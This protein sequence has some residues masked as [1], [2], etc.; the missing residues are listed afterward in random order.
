MLQHIAF[1]CCFSSLI[2]SS[3]AHHQIANPFSFE[4]DQCKDICSDSFFLLPLSKDSQTIC[5]RGCRFFNI[6]D[7][8]EERS[9][10]ETKKECHISCAESYTSTK[11]KGSCTIGCDTMSKK[12][13]SDLHKF[14]PYFEQYSA[15]EQEFDSLEADILLDPLIRKQIQMRYD[16]QYKIPEAYIRTM[17]IDDSGFSVIEADDVA[18]RYKNKLLCSS[19]IPLTIFVIILF[20]LIMC[21][22]K[23][24]QLVQAIKNHK[25]A[26]ARSE[27]A[28]KYA[29]EGAPFVGNHRC[30][31]MC[32]G[33]PSVDKFFDKNKAADNDVIVRD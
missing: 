22:L 31:G 24:V 16:L 28:L 18:Y 19:I 5:Q 4:I 6:I 1:C 7:I 3:S 23:I 26:V 33:M 20:G 17:P 30:F 15:D 32:D 12:K 14:F 2:I 10:N 11:A 29:E 25:V 9:A 13:Q 27:A 8:K 21:T